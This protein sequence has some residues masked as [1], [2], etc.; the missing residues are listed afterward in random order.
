MKKF[1][2]LLLETYVCG[3]NSKHCF[4]GAHPSILKQFPD[5]TLIPFVLLHKAGVTRDLLNHI[6]KLVNAGLSFLEIELFLT[7]LRRERYFHRY[8][9]EFP[10]QS[11]KN[12]RPEYVDIQLS[13]DV[14]THFYIEY[15]RENEEYLDAEMRELIACEHRCISGCRLSPPKRFRRRQATA[16]NTSVFA[17]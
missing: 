15:F 17:G 2:L 9:T 3:K 6:P 5:A 14:L 1:A 11:G 10:R 13:N 7:E 12:T 4:G 16:G 8:L